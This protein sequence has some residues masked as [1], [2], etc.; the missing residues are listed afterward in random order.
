MTSFQHDSFSHREK[1]DRSPSCMAASLAEQFTIYSY[2]QLLLSFKPL[3]KSIS[4]TTL[5]TFLPNNS[6]LSLVNFDNLY[7]LYSYE[8]KKERS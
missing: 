7:M 6:L 1:L 8:E 4:I 5:V 2:R 3:L